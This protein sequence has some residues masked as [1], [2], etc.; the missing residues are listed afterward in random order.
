M[1]FTL[2][3]VIAA[4]AL[5]VAA[6]ALAARYVPA[7]NRPVLVT[8]ALAPYLALGAPAAVVPFAVTH[9]WIGV[10]VAGVLTVARVVVRLRWY[11]GDKAGGEVEVRI[12]SANL[13]YGRADA[14]AVV[15]L[16]RQDADILAVQELTPDKADQLT[17]AGIDETL[18]YRVLRA[19][20]GPAGV[21][22][23]SRHPIVP[24][25][26]YDEFWLGL[27]TARV[28][29]PGVPAE[30]IVVTTHMSAPWPEPIQG[31]RD[32]LTRLAT[33]LSEIG[34]SSDGPVIVAGDLNAT[35]D[36]LAF[37][38][39]LRNGYRDAAEQAGAGLTRT[40]PADILIPPLFAVDHILLRGGT[41]TSV[42]TAAVPGSDHRALIA[43]ITFD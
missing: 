18:P 25:T 28:R 6:L 33:V 9:H 8:A 39:L 20:E 7:V 43:D 17:A 31:W 15:G 2:L 11:V 16:A 3:A 23:W 40:H 14:A 32:D 34:A 5:A 29:I 10:I 24:V 41:A 37:R 1:G 4:A 21:G 30:T 26:D 13:R 27:I 35:P 38:R 36:V 19:R 42:R 12:V 22:V